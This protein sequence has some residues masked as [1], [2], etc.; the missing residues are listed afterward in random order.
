MTPE[1]QKAWER[2]VGREVIID[3]SSHFLFIGTLREVDSA[4]VTLGLSDVHDRSESSSSK[5]KYT[6]D[7]KKYGL[8]ADRKSVS[9]RIENIICVSPMEDVIEY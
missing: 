1:Q 7:T 5:E 4:F 8:K 3:T 2:F 6:M 9:I